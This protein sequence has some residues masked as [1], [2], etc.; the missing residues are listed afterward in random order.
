MRVRIGIA[1]AL[2]GL[3]AA[4]GC[5]GSSHER[6]TSYRI[7]MRVDRAGLLEVTETIRYDFGGDRKHGIYR[8]LPERLRHDSHHDRTYDVLYGL[9]TL[10]GHAVE[11]LTSV[12]D[13]QEVL[14][15]GDPQ[16]TITGRHTYRIQYTV[17]GELN[18]VRGRPQLYWNAVGL[19]WNVPISNVSVR[20]SA[21]GSIGPVACYAGA[22]RSSARCADA[23]ANGKRATFH[24][25]SLAPH[26]ALT[27]VADLPASVAV[28][29]PTLVE[30]TD[31]WY[32]MA[33][34]G[35]VWVAAGIVVAAGLALVA[36]LV[37]W[38]G[39]DRRFSDQVPGLLPAAGQPPAE[40]F[41]P[42]LQSPEGPV[43]FVPPRGV[44]PGSVGVLVRQSAASRDVTAAIVDL[45]VRGYLRI[46]EPRKGS[47]RFAKLRAADRS[48]SRYEATIF[49][50]MF[51]RKRTEVRLADV[52]RRLGK[53]AK[54]VRSEIYD[55]AVTR[56]W[57][58]R[59]PDRT[60]RRWRWLGVVIAAAGLVGWLA[61]LGAANAGAIGFAVLLAGLA[62]M[63]AAHWM[64][65]RTAVGSAAYAQTL[66]FRR[67]I[68]V[69]EAA[70][71]REDERAGVFSRYLP[72]AIAMGEANR[73][74]NTFAAAGV[75][76][77]EVT[78]A[79]YVGNGSVDAAQFSSSLTSFATSVGST[80]SATPASSGGSGFGGG[81]F[82]GGGGGGGGGGSW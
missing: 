41:R 73:W 34:D 40:E 14:R 58:E 31:F 67:Y 33:G 6:I 82:S 10:D 38:R 35:A 13:G 57:Y 36:W 71:L 80:L 44:R 66:G 49:A 75:V 48:L 45:A 21:P 50:R 79:W 42:I 29:P 54:Q 60:R 72:Y 63:G 64:P 9:A 22:A 5:G 1:A 51:P 20:L 17:A 37:W 27:L 62:L 56:G 24:E 7:A 32:R 46:E 11:S 55:D 28:G 39:R 2:A 69:A 76:T 59:R 16:R 26:Q 43:E 53:A 3:F 25:G 15:L 19:G 65:A 61:A 8:Y 74:V 23:A 70:Q 81:G 30:R 47:W 78:A 18:R 4:A 68:R 77:P 52:R 12:K